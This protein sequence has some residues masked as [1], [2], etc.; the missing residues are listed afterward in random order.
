MLGKAL[1]KMS[2]PG[3]IVAMAMVLGIAPNGWSDPVGEPPGGA[4][5]EHLRGPVTVGTLEL[6]NT[7]LTF[8]GSCQGK[9]IN[10][11]GSFVQQGNKTLNQLTAADI[12]AFY[13][14]GLNTDHPSVL[15]CYQSLGIVGPLVIVTAHNVSYQATNGGKLTA[16]VLIMAEVSR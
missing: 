10:F 11:S 7:T 5:P 4:R 2:Y 3:V 6:T 13:Y 16:G 15:G 12:E 1:L 9:P 8:A 14:T